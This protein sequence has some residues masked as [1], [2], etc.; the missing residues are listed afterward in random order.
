MRK[1]FV[2]KANSRE[3]KKRLKHWV[4]TLIQEQINAR[5]CEFNDWLKD[6]WVFNYFIREPDSVKADCIW[7]P[8]LASLPDLG[9]IGYY[10]ILRGDPI[11][12]ENISNGGSIQVEIKRHS[13]KKIEVELTT[14]AHDYI[15]NQF[16]GVLDLFERL[17]EKIEKHYLS[18]GITGPESLN[19]DELSRSWDS[20]KSKMDKL[21]RLRKES[22]R[23]GEVTI[24]KTHACARADG[25]DPKT[26]KTHDPDLW[27]HWYNPNY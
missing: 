17:S 6:Y 5:R 9:L 27:A 1:T 21:R 14:P 23:N 19:E 22:I 4:D 16:E 7:K 10:R 26:A 3:F 25:L 15:G 24:N 20:T 12:P 11:I 8:N 2:I 18:P 13:S